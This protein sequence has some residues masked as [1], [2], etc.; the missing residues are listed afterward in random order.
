ML[1]AT[2][3]RWWADTSS[4]Q[5][6]LASANQQHLA[7]SEQLALLE[8]QRNVLAQATDANQAAQAA[9]GQPPAPSAA[10][11]TV[12]VLEVRLAEAEVLAVKLADAAHAAERR[13]AASQDAADRA[14]D[15]LADARTELERS[16]AAIEDLRRSVARQEART[17]EVLAVQRAAL[18]DLDAARRELADLRV[19]GAKVRRAFRAF[20]GRA[21][22]QSAS[23]RAVRYGLGVE[24]HA[25][26]LWCISRA[27]V[28]SQ[29]TARV[30][31]WTE[32]RDRG[33]RDGS[34]ACA[35]WKW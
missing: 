12:T 14:E 2:L 28:L 6:S 33:C 8:S 15:A 25:C 23:D 10:V 34:C 4:G 17:Q 31:V 13:A 26:W 29:V 18:A 24:P 19:A 35:T 5:E 11:E 3:T 1:R 32:I 20:P 9:A 30:L 21:S 27:A 16:A 7:V 22:H